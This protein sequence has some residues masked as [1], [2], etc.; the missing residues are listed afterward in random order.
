LNGVK[1][2]VYGLKKLNAYAVEVEGGRAVRRP[3]PFPT[4]DCRSCTLLNLTCEELEYPC[5]VILE[6]CSRHVEGFDCE[7]CDRL[8]ECLSEKPCCWDCK[9]LME[10]LENAKEWEANKF[11][12]D[13]F[14]CSWEEFLEAVKMLTE[15]T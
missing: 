4:G 8:S 10:C 11:V 1:K 12:E 14:K 7:E 15:K 5:K 13:Q 3:P 9:H 6:E 2:L